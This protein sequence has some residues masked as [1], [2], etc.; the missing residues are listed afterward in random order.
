VLFTAG[1]ALVCLVLCYWAVDV[2]LYRG[3]WTRLFLIIGMNIARVGPPGFASLLYSLA[4][5]CSC[6]V[7]VWWMY[8]KQIF[9]KA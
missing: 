4:I 6:F 1:C 3:W 9:L 8:R 2:N 7:P 5:V